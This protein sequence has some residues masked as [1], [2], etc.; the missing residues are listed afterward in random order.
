[1]VATAYLYVNSEHNFFG[2]YLIQF[3]QTSS[4]RSCIYV[5]GVVS[6]FSEQS[7]GNQSSDDSDLETPVHAPAPGRGRKRAATI[8][9]AVP[10]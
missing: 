3:N 2:G 4:A 8:F 10:V 6:Y 7:S 1:M 5:V 9:K